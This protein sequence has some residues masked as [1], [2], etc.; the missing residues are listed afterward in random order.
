MCFWSCHGHA[1]G[2]SIHGPETGNLQHGVHRKLADEGS[3]QG[4][5]RQ[6]SRSSV[7]DRVRRGAENG[8]SFLTS[9]T[10]HTLI[11]KEWWKP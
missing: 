11:R 6:W 4:T 10:K 2:G 5:G 1:L 9:A 3:G 7:P 8:R